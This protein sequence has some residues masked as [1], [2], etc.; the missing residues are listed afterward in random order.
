MRLLAPLTRSQTRQWGF[1]KHWR[2]AHY[3]TGDI[4]QD[5]MQKE[6]QC[7]WKASN[8]GPYLRFLGE[9][10]SEWPHLRNLADFM[11]VGTDPLRWKNFHGA[12][13]DAEHV[14]TYPDNEKEREPVQKERLER[15]KVR[16]VHYKDGM[17]QLVG[18]YDNS[19][20]LK[21]ALE[22]LGKSTP[23][24]IAA[25]KSAASGVAA[26]GSWELRLFVV[27]D[28]SREVI[29]QLGHFFD[30][31]P[32]FFC[33]HISDNV[34]FNIRDPFWSPPSLHMDNV[35]KDWYQLRF[36]RARYFP[37]RK[38]FDDGQKSAN[39]FNIGRK[40]YEDE[41]LA[42]WDTDIVASKLDKVL[43]SKKWQ[44]I[45]TEPVKSFSP[46]VPAVGGKFG[47][48]GKEVDVE[49][50]DAPDAGV[51]L[52]QDEK[53]DGKV[54][55]MR[56]KATVWKRKGE[57]GKCDVAVVLLDPTI[58]NGFPLWRGYRNWGK[59][60]SARLSTEERK[61]LLAESR[62]P[63]LTR[64]KNE[65][66]SQAEQDSQVKLEGSK[67]FFEDYMFWALRPETV[68]KQGGAQITAD[69]PLLRLV[70]AEWLTMSQYIKTRLSQIDWEIT[71]PAEF[72][73]QTQIDTILNKL[74]TW[75]R[76][77]PQYREMIS[78]TLAGVLP[79]GPG[80]GT[81]TPK[82]PLD[83]FQQD[84]KLVLAQM[85][86]YERRIDRLTA[87]VTSAIS[88]VDSRRVEQ[89]TLLA[90]F[91]VPLSLVGTLFSMSEDITQIKVTFGYWAAAS[92][93]LLLIIWWIARKTEVRSI[94]TKKKAK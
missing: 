39:K 68:L 78:E 61:G 17:P 93:F 87:V 24:G 74:H 55:L 58:Q 77:V 76:L 49:S 37:S 75:R 88:I 80:T 84:Y 71:H 51:G 25:E 14:Y 9:V 86:E 62:V 91:F 5:R 15:T 10:S 12:D 33:A 69:A 3:H 32:D 8:P 81:K 70:C 19:E 4:Y 53:I 11:E 41:N 36:C 48:K 79:Q 73:T 60:P 66:K 90:A 21:K 20:M 64:R 40:L 52:L 42:Y 59:I 7:E 13:A 16:Q 38:F 54:G 63:S 47:N 72:L 34:W 6:W 22:E 67:S 82:S 29:E 56:T 27:E 26:E 2:S 1:V 44:A 43:P 50:Q 92:F 18:T 45:L 30:I 85:E 31:D 28:L 94:A 57:E 65:S 46:W 89:L 83:A 23:A 35:R